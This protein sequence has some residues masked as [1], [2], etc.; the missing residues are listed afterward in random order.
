MKEDVHYVSIKKYMVLFMISLK[1]CIAIK[2]IIDP[3]SFL[4]NA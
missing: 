4:S 2:N 1:E 3:P